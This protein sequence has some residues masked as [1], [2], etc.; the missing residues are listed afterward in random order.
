MRASIVLVAYHSD[1]WLPDCLQTLAACWNPA[2]A[3]LLVDNSGNT[4]LQ[5]LAALVPGACIVATPR[6]LGFAE[7]NNFALLQGAL[8]GAFVV[9]LNQDTL[10][11]PDWIDACVQLMNERPDVGAV[12]PLLSSFDGAA[13]DEGF[14]HCVRDVPQLRNAH[15]GDLLDGHFEVP[16]LTAAAMVIR[17]DLLQQIGPFDPVFGSYYEDFDLC[18]RIREAGYRLAVC[19]RGTVRHFGGSST[20]TSSQSRRRMQQI[21]RN[22]AIHRIRGRGTHRWGAIL[23]QFAVEFPW[24]LARGLART[25]SSQPPGVQCRAHLD[26]LRLVPRLS[27]ERRDARCWRQYLR[28]IHW[29]DACEQGVKSPALPVQERAAT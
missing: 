21:V 26:L 22:R 14:A 3:L 18:R 10:S 9:L 2:D 15:P 13:W 17:T 19:G 12:A 8:D 25:P 11:E 1:R 29:I 4:R 20:Q 28:T 23:R 6:P 27:S 24:N 7:A 5:D 16:R